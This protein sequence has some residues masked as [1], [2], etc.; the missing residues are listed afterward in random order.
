MEFSNHSPSPPQ[1]TGQA[2]AS[3]RNAIDSVE[4][5]RLSTNALKQ[6]EEKAN[7]LV[8]SVVQQEGDTVVR[9][10]AYLHC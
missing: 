7:R 2:T 1:S 5:E 8:S 3:L 9:I 10:I 4:T 6:Y